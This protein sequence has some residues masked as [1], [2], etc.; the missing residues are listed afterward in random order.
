MAPARTTEAE[1]PVPIGSRPREWSVTVVATP[2]V[3]SLDRRVAFG[4]RGLAIGREPPG[5]PCIRLED[6]RL[7][8]HHASIEL[9][10]AGHPVLRDEG[11]RNGTRVGGLRVD[12]KFLHD[13]DVVRVGQSVLLVEH[14]EAPAAHPG[15]DDLGLEGASAAVVAVRRLLLLTAPSPMPIL[16]LG[17][18]GSGKERV[19]EAVHRVSGRRG[20]FVP[21]N[22]AALPE[23]LVESSLFG[24]RR[25]AF[26]GA[27]A[28]R[29]GAFEAADGGTLFLD[30][31]GE[32][33]PAVQAK[34]LRVLETGQVTRVGDTSPRRVDV[35]VVAA[36]NSD[37]REA[38]ADGRFRLDLWTRLAGVV[39]DLPGLAARRRDIL[40]LFRSL[41]PPST[42]SRPMA[43]EVAEALLLHTW[44]GNVRELRQLAQRLALLH[45]HAE[46]WE[47]GMLPP[48]LAPDPPATEAAPDPAVPMSREELVEI[49]ERVGGNVTRAATIVGRTRRQ[50]YR[51]MDAL[52]IP[53][54]AGR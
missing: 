19:A 52:A 35:R 10:A 16:V 30:E 40:T 54:G 23:T 28:D 15:G 49:L 47:L 2:D 51:W 33:A 29:E 43:A 18:P 3:A 5:A 36:T 8:R 42:R 39:V 22:C 26:T 27:I 37:L 38:I 17:P 14:G 24:H 46:R 6:P 21:L 11:S 1:T 9:D 20:A 48:E 44:P 45:P 41:S 7:S 13:G 53:R 50:L 34:L 12:H 25:G 32:T 31:V 4:T